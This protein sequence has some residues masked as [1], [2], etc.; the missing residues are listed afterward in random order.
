MASAAHSSLRRIVLCW[1]QHMRLRLFYDRTTLHRLIE[2]T[3]EM[4]YRA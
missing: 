2:A 4:G 1:S 3:L